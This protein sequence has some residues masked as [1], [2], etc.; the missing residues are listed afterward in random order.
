MRNVEKWLRNVRMSM[1]ISCKKKKKEKRKEQKNN[2][3]RN[4]EICQECFAE[5]LT[6]S[7]RK[8]EKDFFNLVS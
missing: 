4:L 3:I 5:F 1:F 7:K 6:K 2:K 8:S